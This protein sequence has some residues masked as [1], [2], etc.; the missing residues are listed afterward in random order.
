M[1]NGHFLHYL[2]CVT[3]SSL[4]V[5]DPFII[6]C[7]ESVHMACEKV[8]MLE[9]INILNLAITDKLISNNNSRKLQQHKIIILFVFYSWS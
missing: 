8:F 9:I 1:F 4:T 6:R 5:Q 7:I 3:V 2:L